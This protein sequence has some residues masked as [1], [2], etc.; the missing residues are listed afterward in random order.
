LE[1]AILVEA[2]FA[3]SILPEGKKQCVAEGVNLETHHLGYIIEHYEHMCDVPGMLLFQQA[4]TVGLTM[5]E[6]WFCSYAMCTLE[7]AQR[8]F[9]IPVLMQYILSA[10]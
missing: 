9:R 4:M 5:K 10:A 2:V 1:A 3:V 7:F 6:A 8:T